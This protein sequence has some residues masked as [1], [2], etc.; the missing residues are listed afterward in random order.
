LLFLIAEGLPAAALRNI[1]ELACG[2]LV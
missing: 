1:V 2:A